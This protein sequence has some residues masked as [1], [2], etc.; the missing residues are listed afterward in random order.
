MGREDAFHNIRCFPRPVHA[1]PF[2]RHRRAAPPPYES[3]CRTPI[4]IAESI[5][6][7]KEN[8]SLSCCYGLQVHEDF[9]RASPS[10][11]LIEWEDFRFFMREK[12][13]R[14]IYARILWKFNK[15]ISSFNVVLLVFSENWKNKKRYWQNLISMVWLWRL[16]YTNF[17]GGIKPLKFFR[18]S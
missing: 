15:D 7:E 5:P 9:D 3:T 14:K 8:I 13:Q 6:A 10:P 11:P 16:V 12:G 4:S 1:F 2:D 17:R 18:N